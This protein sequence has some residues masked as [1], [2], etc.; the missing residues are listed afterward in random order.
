MLNLYQAV[1]ENQ[2]WLKVRTKHEALQKHF[3]NL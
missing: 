2:F 3:P 1:L